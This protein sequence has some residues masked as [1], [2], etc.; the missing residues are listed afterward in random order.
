MTTLIEWHSSKNT[1]GIK[2]K[3]L[4]GFACYRTHAANI[5]KEIKFQKKYI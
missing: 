4:P 1:N 5:H 2:N 3:V